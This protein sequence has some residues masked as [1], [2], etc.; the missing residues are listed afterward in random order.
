MG[1][2]EIFSIDENGAGWKNLNELSDSEKLDLELGILFDDVKILCVNC[3]V[4]IPKGSGSYCVK[5]TP[6]N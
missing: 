1:Y 6:K 2:I 5:H 3:L 4:E